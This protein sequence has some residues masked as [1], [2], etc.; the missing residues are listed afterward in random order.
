MSVV[1][2]NP[3]TEILRSWTP[4]SLTLVTPV[5][6]MPGFDWDVYGLELGVWSWTQNMTGLQIGVVNTVDRC[7]GLQIGVINTAR[8]MRGVQIGV[9]NVINDS[10]IPFFPVINAWF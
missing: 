5:A 4:V 9:V 3:K 8:Q 10:D 6:I 1:G 7:N 2:R